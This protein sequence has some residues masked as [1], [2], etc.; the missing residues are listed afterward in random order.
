MDFFSAGNVYIYIHIHMIIHVMYVYGFHRFMIL[1]Q[2]CAAHWINWGFDAQRWFVLGQ[3]DGLSIGILGCPG[4][5]LLK[6]DGALFG[7]EF[8][9]NKPGSA[10]YKQT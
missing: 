2:D 1:H 3:V 8:Q 10:A 5:R 7:V 4:V 6:Y 9:V